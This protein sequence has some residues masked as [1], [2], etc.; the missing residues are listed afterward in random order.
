V[1]AASRPDVLCEELLEA[2]VAAPSADNRH[3]FE[4][5]WE[6][7]T[8]LVRGNV[9]FDHALHHRKVLALISFGAVVE[10]VCVR[11]ARLGY[12]T[13]IRWFPDPSQ[14][15][16]VARIELVDRVA[17]VPSIVSRDMAI[18]TRH[19]NRS[20]FYSGPSLTED[21]LVHFADAVADIDGVSLFFC[22]TG[23]RRARLAQ[24]IG[25][26]ER[27]RFERYPLHRE[28]FSSIRFDVGWKAS[29]QFGLPPGALA[30][31]PG[32][33]L[34]FQGL[35][36]WPVMNALRR[37][38][39]SRL[40]AF[41]AASLPARLAPHRGVLTTRLPLESGAARVGMALQRVWLEAETRGLALQPFAGAPL[42]ALPGYDDVSSDTR[43]LLQRGWRH[44]TDELPLMVFR[45]GRA[46][47]V[48]VFAGRPAGEAFLRH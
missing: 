9:A 18:A 11:A 38:G 21:E 41:R 3:C 36:H 31:E 13:R 33:R 4:L 28:L 30:V 44:L 15:A 47:R 16:L 26:A 48:R 7:G 6:D 22:D 24:L 2:A 29:A 20:V 27:E 23:T 40:L 45:L 8:L 43:T 34:M 12:R 39:L 19:T 42:L 5:E 37:V 35:R 1:N 46:K 25:I 17:P 10:N 32:A 14:P